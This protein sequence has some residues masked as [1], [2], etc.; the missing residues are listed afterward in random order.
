[1]RDARVSLLAADTANSDVAPGAGALRGNTTTDDR[2]HYEFAALAPGDYKIEVQAEPWYAAGL[3]GRRLADTAESSLDPLLDVVYPPTWFP[4]LQER[5]SAEILSLHHGEDRQADVNLI[6]IPATHL[7]LSSPSPAEG[8]IARGKVFPQVER[9]SSDGSPFYNTSMRIDSQG[10]I[11]IGGLAPG[12]YSVS[13]QGTNGSLSPQF[14]RVAPGSQHSLDL[15]ADAIPAAEVTIHLDGDAGHADVALT[16]V[17]SGA[18]FLSAG[19]SS[20]QRRRDPE[21]LE[22]SNGDRKMEVPPARYQVT[23]TGDNEAYLSAV[24]LKNTRVANRILDLA[25]GSTSLTLTVG[26]GRAAVRG[27]TTLAAQ[28][29]AGAMILLVPATFGQPGSITMLGRDETNTDGSFS[30][31][32]IIPVDYILLAIDHGWT[33]NWRDPGVL[34]RYLVNGMALSLE[35]NAKVN[36]DIAAQRP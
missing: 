6:P 25:S 19:R 27:L 21:P 1:M 24:T 2:G 5:R 28:P 4:G 34:Q 30:I 10:Q 32:G 35:P 22:T 18:R 15:S 20:L 36:Q 31:V 7:H 8:P 13:P 12:L 16:D 17:D 26:R 3:H 23:L 29:I 33:L 9:V 11:D 14:L